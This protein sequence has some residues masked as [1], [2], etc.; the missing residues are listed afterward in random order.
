VLAT[1]PGCSVAM[2]GSGVIV[3]LPGYGGVLLQ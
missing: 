3:S 2:E 1:A